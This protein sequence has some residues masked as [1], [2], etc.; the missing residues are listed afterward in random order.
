M[1][2]IILEFSQNPQINLP[3]VQGVKG[4]A[5]IIART[6]SPTATPLITEVGN[7]FW[8]A[9]IPGTYT[10]FGGVVVAAN[11][12]AVISRDAAGV[13]SISQTALV[14]PQAINKIIP[15]TAQAYAS[16]DQV[17][18]LGKDWVSNAAIVAGDV[19]GTSSKWLERLSGYN[20]NTL[21]V[22]YGASGKNLYNKTDRTQGKY[23]DN[24]NI[25]NAPGGQEAEYG[26]S[27]LINVTGLTYVTIS[28]AADLA[29]WVFTK[30]DGVKL[31]YGASSTFPFTVSVPTDAVY[32]Q[33]VDMWHNNR[34]NLIQCE[35][36]TS[37]TTYAAYV[38]TLSII[39]VN[40]LLLE[41]SRL[42]ED[43]KILKY[44]VLPTD[45]IPL[46]YF[47]EKV[48]VNSFGDTGGS[49][50]NLYNKLARI[51]GKYIENGNI[52][53]APVGQESNY[54]ISPLINIKGLASISVKGYGTTFN[55]WRFS[56]ADGTRLTYGVFS[57]S[58]N[59]VAVPS[60]AVWFQFTD[61]WNDDFKNT[62]QVE[63]GNIAT[64]YAAYVATPTVKKI[65]NLPIEATVI[66]EDL[67]LIKY[68][69]LDTDV[70][71]LSYFNEKVFPANK[72]AGRKIAWIGDSMTQ[73]NEII[74]KV[75][76]AIGCVPINAAVAGRTYSDGVRQ[77]T[78]VSSQLPQA[79]VVLL[80]TN[81]FAQGSV[82][83]TIGIYSGTDFTSNVY[84]T[85]QYLALNNLTK[86]VLVCTPFQRNAPLEMPG[87]FSTN[88]RGLM[89]YDYVVRIRQIAEM[90]AFPLLDFYRDSG[91]NSENI[92]SFSEDG[93][94]I[95]T[96]A[97]GLK[98]SHRA[99]YLQIKALN[100]LFQ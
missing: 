53:N 20:V 12:F 40:N 58:P 66:S 100:E 82:I 38:G 61:Q 4:D 89:L 43:L 9:I 8:Y 98:G 91:I 14:I 87:K 22:D 84:K 50:K 67:K 51:Q 21:T 99:S 30:K 24:G 77:A 97:N 3:I 15:W 81:D 68:P 64:T 78:E 90:F 56:S 95:Q 26:I 86:P 19:P 45:I 94:H 48:S 59:T 93:L 70:V 37:A 88:S 5:A 7:I 11:S 25:N 34:I 71:S 42:A 73:D 18:Y 27:K 47:N 72:W 63:A 62:I 33:F 69:K 6:V 28:G 65:N 96:L 57:T 10:N 23:I 17:N 92:M 85:L 35:S 80:G 16:G 74:N 52:I 83:G 41:A 54:G 49:G 1:S 79:I 76:T 31:T 55:S 29:P 39:K 13:F 2:D 60:N 32:F 46:S 44:P 36:G 75:V